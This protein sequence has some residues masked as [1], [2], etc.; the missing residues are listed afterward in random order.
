MD[1]HCQQ[2]KR[3]FIDGVEC[4]CDNGCYLDDTDTVV[5]GHDNGY[6]TDCCGCKGKHG[7]HDGKSV[8]GGTFERMDC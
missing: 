5:I 1:N 3:E 6:C 2:C 8:A 7:I 4:C